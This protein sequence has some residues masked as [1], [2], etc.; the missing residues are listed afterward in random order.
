MFMQDSFHAS[1]VPRCHLDSRGKPCSLKDTVISLADNACHL[2][3]RILGDECMKTTSLL[4]APSAVHLTTCFSPESQHL[5]LSVK[6]SL[7]LSPHHRFFRSLFNLWY[8]YHCFFILSTINY[9][10]LQD[11]V[12]H[13]VYVSVLLWLRFPLVFFAHR[14]I[15]K[16][17]MLEYTSFRQI[18][19]TRICHETKEYV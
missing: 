6:A 18:V 4:T 19:Q 12:R 1:Y 7:P 16:R 9:S 2:R 3:C 14:Y 10:L 5:R 15:I 8:L 13:F 11:T 17:Q